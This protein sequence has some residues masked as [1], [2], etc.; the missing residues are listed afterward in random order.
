MKGVCGDCPRQDYQEVDHSED[1]SF[2][3]TMRSRW[4]PMTVASAR[5]APFD[6]SLRVEW[7]VDRFA[8]RNESFPKYRW[9]IDRRVQ[10]DA[11]HPTSLGA[12]THTAFERP[13]P[14]FIHTEGYHRYHC[15]P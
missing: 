3:D 10:E 2:P 5:V 6:G 9:T 4:H 12:S 14:V 11:E 8:D 13:L 1:L 15:R 7:C